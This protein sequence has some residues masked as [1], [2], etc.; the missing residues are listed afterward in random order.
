MKKFYGRE[1]I[2]SAIIKAL[3]REKCL[4]ITGMRGVGKSFFLEFLASRLK[5]SKK[6]LPILIDNIMGISLSIQLRITLHRLLISIEN[7]DQN[8]ETLSIQ[9]TIEKIRK[10]TGLIPVI[11]I[12]DAD[13]ADEK[14][15]QDILRKIHQTKAKIVLVGVFPVCK[16]KHF[17]L[18]PLDREAFHKLLRDKLSNMITDDGINRLYERLGG[19]PLYLEVLLPRITEMTKYK[20][21]PLERSIVDDIINESVTHG[22]LRSVLKNH[23][24][25]YVSLFGDYLVKLLTDNMIKNEELIKR[26]IASGLASLES[27]K[28]VIKD[29]LLR[30]F[31][32]SKQKNEKDYLIYASARKKSRA[33][34]KSGLTFIDNSLRFFHNETLINISNDPTPNLIEKLIKISKVLHAKKTLL[35]V[36]KSKATKSL[37]K[38]A[39]AHGIKVLQLENN[40]NFYEEGLKKAM[41]SLEH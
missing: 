5:L 40:K 28:L 34:Q 31:L 26:I 6:Y 33:I 12:D 27:G 1:T 23:L 11:L 3:S 19:I 13:D 25:S 8:R 36:P 18:N 37:L 39:H 9:H 24:R 16:C 15:I 17:I 38:K 30:D 14:E 7:G 29:P 35:I 21:M 22:A 10:K 41:I 20:K 2:L 4:V 32:N